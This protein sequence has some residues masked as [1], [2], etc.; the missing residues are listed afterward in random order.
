MILVDHLLVH[1][2]ELK[3]V[4]RV[5]LLAHGARVSG[6]GLASPGPTPAP[7]PGPTPGPTPGPILGRTPGSNVV[8][9]KKKQVHCI[10]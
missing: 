7:P 1:E 4:E 6:G 8:P 3:V 2:F 10:V 9:L 5:T